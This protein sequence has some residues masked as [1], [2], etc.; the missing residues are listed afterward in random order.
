VS[1][2]VHSAAYLAWGI[3]PPSLS[4]GVHV[5]RENPVRNVLQWEWGSYSSLGRPIV[6]LSQEAAGT[7]AECCCRPPVR[8][9]TQWTWCVKTYWAQFKLSLTGLIPAL[10]LCVRS[11]FVR[12]R[13]GLNDRSRSHAVD[14]W[15]I[16][17]TIFLFSFVSRIFQMSHLHPCYFT[18]LLF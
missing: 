2:R 4:V 9:I 16:S 6:M 17:R 8:F 5:K 10:D 18:C 14:K 3:R 1:D 15:T 13:L 11:T 12:G 7:A